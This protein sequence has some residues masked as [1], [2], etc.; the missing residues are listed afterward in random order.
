MAVGHQR[1]PHSRQP[2][3]HDHGPP[4]L[5]QAEYIPK[6]APQLQAKGQRRFVKFRPH[7]AAGL[8]SRR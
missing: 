6:A 7:Q 1:L 8:V 3:E 2:I 5:L 4:D